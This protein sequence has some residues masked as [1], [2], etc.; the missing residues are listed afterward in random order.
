ME[1]S[2]VQLFAMPEKPVRVFATADI[3]EQSLSRLREKGYDVE[4][5][6]QVE[7]PPKSLIHEKVR[8]GIDA[9]ITTLRDRIDAEV[10]AAGEGSLRVVA[11]CAVGFDNI[12]R[13]AANRCGIPFTNT[14]DV[15]TEATAEFA[16]FIMGAVSRKLYSS[17]RLVEQR[18]WGSWHPYHPFL[19][20]EV[21]GKTVG[22]VGTGRIGKAFAKKCIGLDM[23]L[24]LY[25]PVQQDE[26]FVRMAQREMG[27][28]FDAGFSNRL[29]SAEYVSFPDLLSLADYVSLHVPLVMAGQGTPTYHLVNEEAFCQMKPGAYLINTSRGPVVDERALYEALIQRRIAGA[30]LDVYEEEPLPD[31]SPLLDS[32]LR[33]RLRLFHHFASGTRETRLSPD[34]DVGMAGRTVQAVIDVIEGRY[35]ANPAEMPFVVNKE[36]F[37]PPRKK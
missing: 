5:Y 18:Q 16:F 34:P 6:P 25:D 8:G 19:G 2:S 11:Q 3:G 20:D 26:H 28:R 37:E 24:L 27:L 9:L 21:T 31:S 32:S 29:R 13:A 14:A 12:D 1:K 7:A 23:D 30:A 33:D 17:E 4:V 10:L 36:A 15:L 35:G 22:I